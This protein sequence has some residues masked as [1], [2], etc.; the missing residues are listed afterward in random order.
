MFS[1]CLTFTLKRKAC[2]IEFTASG[3]QSVF[4]TLRFRDGRVWSKGLTV[5]N[6]SLF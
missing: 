5:K 2:V 1:T 4:E 6:E 3:L